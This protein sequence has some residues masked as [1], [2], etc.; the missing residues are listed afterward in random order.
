MMMA[1]HVAPFIKFLLS[2]SLFLPSQRLMA[3]SDMVPH[4]HT[5]HYRCLY[6][7]S[8]LHTQLVDSSLAFSQTIQ[9]NRATVET[10]I[11][12]SP[13]LP[14]LTELRRKEQSARLLLRL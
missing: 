12:F 13:S 10:K 5:L 7:S 8:N 2:S 1:R 6:L 3:T 14:F 11:L 9:Y 4:T